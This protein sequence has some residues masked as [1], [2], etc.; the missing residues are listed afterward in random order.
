VIYQVVAPD[1]PNAFPALK[2]LEVVPN[3]LPRS[4]TTF[5]GREREITEVTRLLTEAHL[6]TITGP[7]GSGKTRLSLKIATSLFDDYPDGVW[8]VEF[9]PLADPARVPQLLATTLGV[10]EE[11]GRP[12]L[13]TLVD[14]LRPK[15]VLL[16]FDNCEHLIDACARLADSLLRACPDVKIVSASREALGLTGEVTFRVPPLSLPDS[17]HVPPLDGLGPRVVKELRRGAAHLLLQVVLALMPGVR[18]DGQHGSVELG[19]QRVSP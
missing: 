17:R 11:A 9:A 7:G 12:L 16:L 3:N 15:H 19:E 4:L 13:A 6:L 18:R 14:H 1:L 10:R 2:S 8:L 5:I